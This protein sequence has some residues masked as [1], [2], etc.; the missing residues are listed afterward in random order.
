METARP[1]QYWDDYASR[2]KNRSLAETY[3]LRPPYP[4]ETYRILLSL[5]GKSRERV[6]DVGC[7][8]GKIARTL[9]EHVDSVDAVDFS[10]EM[11]RV[12]KSLPNGNHPNLRWINGRVEDVR[13]YPPYRMVTAGAS[14]HWMDWDMVFPRFEEVLTPDG[15]LVIINGDRPIGAPWHDAELSLIRKY[16]TNKHY[17]QIDLVQELANR[18]HIHLI[19]DKRTTPVNFSQPLTDYVQSFHS[20]QSLSK[21]DMGE[22]NVRTFDAELSQI[23]SNFVD[24]DGFL[25]FQLETRITWV[26]PLA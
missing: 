6:L 1:R 26:R 7:G 9:V 18:G 24:A 2:F 10:Q 14:I 16:S 8:T 11:I 22:E 21:E 5:L 12:G 3:E 19:G 23:L 17:K 25:S 20:R 4:E 13:L 15:Y